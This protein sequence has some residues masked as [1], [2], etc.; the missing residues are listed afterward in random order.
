MGFWSSALKP[1]R[2]IKDTLFLHPLSGGKLLWNWKAAFATSD[3]H[4][5]VGKNLRADTSSTS[6]LHQTWATGGTTESFNINHSLERA[7]KSTRTWCKASQPL[8]PYVGSPGLSVAIE[9]VLFPPCFL[10]L[11]SLLQVTL[12]NVAHL[13]KFK[14]LESSEV[15]GRRVGKD[16]EKGKFLTERECTRGHEQ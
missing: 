9:T 15:S 8:W 14:A 13:P 2:E 5:E 11:T 1:I 6:N 10:L 4:Q 3:Q 12:R 16:A 7:L